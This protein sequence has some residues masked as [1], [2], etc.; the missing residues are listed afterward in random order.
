M[1]D[2]CHDAATVNVAHVTRNRTGD[3]IL[4]VLQRI[5]KNLLCL[6]L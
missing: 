2:T 5:A 1:S 4:L 6:G 3:S